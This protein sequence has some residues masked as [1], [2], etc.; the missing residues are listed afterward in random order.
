[1]ASRSIKKKG[2][3]Q[4]MRKRS[5]SFAHPGETGPKECSTDFQAYLK[6][7]V[8]SKATQHPETPP[9]NEDEE[10]QPQRRLRSYSDPSG[11]LSS[12]KT[13][14]N[15]ILKTIP[16]TSPSK[17]RRSSLSQTQNLTSDFTFFEDEENED[18]IWS[19][20]ESFDSGDVEIYSNSPRT[21]RHSCSEKNVRFGPVQ[22]RDP[23]L[24]QGIEVF[25]WLPNGNRLTLTGQPGMKIKDLVADVTMEY[26]I[27]R[28]RLR[29]ASTLGIVRDDARLSTLAR[30]EIIIESRCVEETE[31]DADKRLAVLNEFI[32]TERA[33]CNLL[34]S[35]FTTY[36]EPLRKSPSMPKSDHTRIFSNVKQMV[37]VSV[38]FLT[39]LEEVASSWDPNTSTIGDLFD[40]EFLE[41]FKEYYAHFRVMRLLL[42]F[43]Q[44]NNKDFVHLCRE[45]RGASWHTLDSLLLLPV[46]HRFKVAVQYGMSSH[47]SPT[48]HPTEACSLGLP[49]Y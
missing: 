35:I 22:M 41:E 32:S 30:Q 13:T 12:H 20:V 47:L 44:N 1:M 25:T 6:A 37:T 17:T 34:Q 14:P 42:V 23:P 28:H 18:D 16:E 10:E 24:N 40:E 31:E 29:R 33:Y 46:S 8:E 36:K 21:R 19:S 7:I 15:P 26:Q 11:G 2:F 27:P 48:V 9:K 43:L 5:A 49:A 4:G 39:K 38:T 45:K 3:F